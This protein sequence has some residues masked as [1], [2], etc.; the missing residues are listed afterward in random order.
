MDGCWIW[1]CG[2][3]GLENGEGRLAHPLLKRDEHIN[4][5]I[6]GTPGALLGID[7]D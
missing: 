1:L 6:E 2:R 4:I 7:T 3:D 5:A